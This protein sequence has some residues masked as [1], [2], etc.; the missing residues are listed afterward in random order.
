MKDYE[1]PR[2]SNGFIVPA[3][4]TALLSKYHIIRYYNAPRESTQ[5][6]ANG[7]WVR[8]RETAHKKC[9]VFFLEWR[10]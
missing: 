1:C 9:I 3:N 4:L 7:K 6:Q 10:D 5:I 2:E 8:K